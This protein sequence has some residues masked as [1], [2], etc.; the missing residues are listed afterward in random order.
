LDARLRVE[1]RAELARLHRRLGATMV[2]VTHDQE[3]AMTLGDRVAV[4]RDGILE[5]VGP[6]MEVY[7][8]PATAFV[9][10]FVGSPAMNLLPGLLEPDGTARLAGGIT[11]RGP[12]GSA[13]R[14]ILGT[15][16][17]HV[18][19]VERGAGDAD[20]EVDLV[21]PRGGD[22]VVHVRIGGE[23]GPATLRALAPADRGSVG[24]TVGV[25]LDRGALHWFDAGS[26]RRLE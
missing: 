15:R 13:R 19:L 24:G 16:P 5:Q 7:R 18:A 21:E 17:Q 23:P 14:V 22:L 26:G 10:G 1:T 3:E 20:G 4:L 8:W 6:P 11:L 12:G 9:A 2:Y 25:R